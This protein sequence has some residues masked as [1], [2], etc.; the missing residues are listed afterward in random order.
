MAKP[1]K[2]RWLPMRVKPYKHQLK[3][4]ELSADSPAFAWFMEQGTGKSKVAI[5]NAAYLYAAGKIAALV[6]IAPNNVNRAW[7][8]EHIVAHM[9]EAVPWFGTYFQPVSARRVW[10]KKAW[11]D[12]TTSRRP[13]LRVLAFNYE[14]FTGANGKKNALMLRDF[15]RTFPTMLL[16][17]ESHRIKNPR[18]PTSKNILDVSDYAKYRRIAT[19]TPSGGK[20]F[21]YFAQFTF[22]DTDILGTTSFAAFRAHYSLLEETGKDATSGVMRHIQQRLAAKYGKER[23]QH[24]APQIVKRDD[25]GQPIYRNLDELQR[26]IAPYSYRVLKADCLDLPPKIWKKVLCELKGEQRRV[27]DQV[28]EDFFSVYEEKLLTSAMAMARLA[29]LLQITGGFFHSDDGKVTPFPE[30]AKLDALVERLE[31]LPDKKIV[32]WANYKPEIRAIVLRLRE[33][34]GD[35]ST[36]AFFGDVAGNDRDANK[37]R[38]I[39]DDTCRFFVA[40][41]AAGGTGVDGLQ[42]ASDHMFYYSNALALILRLQ[43]EDRLHRGGVGAKAKVNSVIVED[44]VAEDTKDDRVLGFLRAGKDIADTCIGDKL[45]EWV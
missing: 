22:L 25:E 9:P 30:N 27:Y 26:L 3:A 8:K 41:Q 34:Y 33:I 16:L 11:E 13:G 38:F 45:S 35:A 7:I 15:M 21:D 29:R 44:I 6:V 40:Q 12:A 19:G 18:A 4:L 14:T 20:P 24:M 43:S 1:V 2:N 36:V 37:A 39:Q 5:D 10:N 28:A 23:A 31:D 42:L 17:D 32:V